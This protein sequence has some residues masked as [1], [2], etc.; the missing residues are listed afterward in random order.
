MAIRVPQEDRRGAVYAPCAFRGAPAGP[1]PSGISEKY[2]FEDPECLRVLCRID[3]GVEDG[4]LRRHEV[5]DGSGE[6]IG[7]IERHPAKGRKKHPSW[8][9]RQPGH[10]EVVGRSDGDLIERGV[11]GLIE[12]GVSFYESGTLGD[13]RV[14]KPKKPRMIHWNDEAGTR[15]MS[16]QGNEHKV[17]A[18]WLDRRLAFAFALLGD[19]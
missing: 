3:D 15:V 4:V 17:K 12:F 14:A 18:A 7:T 5:K 6:I 9:I 11:V 16:S 19:N 10:S 2:L 8:R 1:Q 13:Q